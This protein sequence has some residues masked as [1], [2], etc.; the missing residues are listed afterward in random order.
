MEE[1]KLITITEKPAAYWSAHKALYAVDEI[2]SEMP[3]I[4]SDLATHPNQPF[5]PSKPWSLELYPT[6][7]CQIE[8]THCYSQLRNKEYRFIGMDPN[9]MEQ[10]HDSI[11]NLGIRGIQYCG[12]GEPLLWRKGGITKYIA[13][14]N[15]EVSRAGMAS[16]LL[17]GDALADAKVLDKMVFIEV[18]VF[19]YDDETYNLVAGRPHCS[20]EV[21]R[22]VKLLQE[23]KRSNGIETPS[24]NAKILINQVNYKWLPKIF[25]WAQRTGFDNIHLRIVD[26]YEEN[27]PIS[28][29]PS[30]KMEFYDLVL[31]FS[32]VEGIKEWEN[33]IEYILGMKGVSLHHSHCR[34][35][36]L[37]LN[38]WVIA[39]GE[40]YI[41]GPQWGKKEYCIG[42]LREAPLE[43]IWGGSRHLE[44]VNQIREN[45]H[46]SQCYKIG[47][48][49][50]KQTIAIDDVLA[51]RGFIPPKIEFEE[52]H[53]WF[54]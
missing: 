34:T 46:N 37:G 49:H 16:N 14:L 5:I 1:I 23:I 36:Q 18:A 7:A 29:T 50:I 30:Q 26:D 40:V 2:A 9:L 53:A 45:M 41:C 24:I 27:N 43:M 15:R 6:M 48:R 28:L 8:C 12:G 38:A 10:L 20:K 31:E 19:S 42:N 51:G 13:G 22:V 17:M 25:R 32:K 39:N 3:T 4:W 33:N 52:R 54:L 44:I 11:R 35:I 21:E 47:C